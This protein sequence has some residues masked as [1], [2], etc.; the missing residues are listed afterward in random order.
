MVLCIPQDAFRGLLMRFIIL[1]LTALCGLF[2]ITRSAEARVAIHVDLAS[3]TMHVSSAS[4]EYI[5]RISSAR[6]GFRTP[7]GTFGVQR[8]EAMHR[9]HKY[10]N[11]PMP[12]SIFFAGGYAI[13]GTYATGALGRPASHGCIRLAPHNAAALYKMVKSEGA[14]IAIDNRAPDRDRVYAQRSHKPLYAYVGTG[15]TVHSTTAL[16]HS[17]VDLSLPLGYAPSAPTVYEWIAHPNGYR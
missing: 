11:S 10:H 8:M 16:R 3:Q 7:K 9:S 17:F 5:W 15:R 13:H 1:V 12:H 14:R 6:S 2:T 4:G